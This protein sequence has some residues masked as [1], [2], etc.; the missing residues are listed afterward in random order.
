MPSNII[1]D[2]IHTVQESVCVCLDSNVL[3]LGQPMAKCFRGLDH[4]LAHLTKSVYFVCVSYRQLFTTILSAVTFIY[5]SC[6]F[7]KNLLINQLIRKL[8]RQIAW[9]CAHRITNNSVTLHNI[10]ETT[11]KRERERE[12]NRRKTIYK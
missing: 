9:L 7:I 2:I 3:D 1:A 10:I 8:I 12:K 6:N 4:P 5:Y 11:Q